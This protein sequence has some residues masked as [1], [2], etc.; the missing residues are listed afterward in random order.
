MP[1][2]LGARHVPTPGALHC[3][4][5]GAPCVPG[6]ASATNVSFPYRGV[7]PTAYAWGGRFAS[8]FTWGVGAS[9]AQTEGAWVADGKG[10]SIWDTFSGAVLGGEPN[11]RMAPAPAN[12]SQ[13]C[14]ANCTTAVA[15]AQ[16][17]ARARRGTS[18][19][20]AGVGANLHLRAIADANLMGALGVRAYRFSF[21]WPRLLP[22][23]TVAGGVSARGV[24]YYQELISD[25]LANDI[26]PLGTLYHWDLPQAL[27]NESFSGW[28]DP[29][30]VSLFREY[31]AFVFSTFG[32][33]VRCWSTFH[34]PLDFCV[35]GYGDGSQAPAAPLDIGTHPYTC[36]HHVLLAHAEAA[37]A[38]RADA[39]LVARGAQLGMTNALGWSEPADWGRRADVAAAERANLWQ[40]AWFAE[41]V[42]GGRGEYPAAMVRRL[43]G[44]LPRFTAE[45][46]A[47]ING[48]CDF[49]A[50]STAE[51]RLAS[52][53][54]T[55]ADYGR[56]G[57]PPYSYYSDYEAALS[58]SE[59]WP[60]SSAGQRAAPW[61]LRAALGWVDGR[62]RRPEIQVLAD[63][64]STAADESNWTRVLS[65]GG[66]VRYHET[67]LSELQRAI[68][69]DGVDVRGYYVRDALDSFEWQAAYTTRS[70]LVAVDWPSLERT[71]KASA[72]W[73]AETIHDGRVADPTPYLAYPYVHDGAS[74]FLYY[75]LFSLLILA[76]CVPLAICVVKVEAIPNEP[77]SM[78]KDLT[79]EDDECCRLRDRGAATARKHR[80]EFSAPVAQFSDSPPSAVLPDRAASDREPGGELEP[81]PGNV[82]RRATPCMESRAAPRASRASCESSAQA[83]REARRAVLVGPGELSPW[84]L[85]GHAP[86]RGSAATGLAGFA[87]LAMRAPA[88]AEQ[89]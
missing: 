59:D 57:G 32:D 31:A 70:G 1:G 58:H 5:G 50:L 79:D 77:P 60:R 76:V 69:D 81:R 6:V 17:D 29:G 84:P 87:G 47:A 25:L 23:G 15:C 36:G 48:S 86:A 74:H 42:W 27:Q 66:R 34:E 43:G 26:T 82:A 13:A 10:H 38:F 83:G 89:L 41:P 19:W 3:P 73:Y 30:V 85:C 44:R 7:Y 37:A 64:W 78:M 54:R 62:Y 56:P 4:G 16:Y 46:A 52:A 8:D 71:A 39:Q 35:H 14:P 2:F 40:L 61:A 22:H 88:P 80:R 11:P 21:S 51:P 28:L 18:N 45:Q 65:D 63:G 24:R 72:R 20:V 12:A 55:P 75:W 33:R 9:A 67:Q 53:E 68:T 49:F